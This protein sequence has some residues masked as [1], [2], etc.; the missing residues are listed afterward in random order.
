MEA[1]I[2]KFAGKIIAGL[3]LAANSI[4][5]RLMAGSGMA[6]A[7]F[8]YAYPQIKAVL[9][10]KF[11]ALPPQAVELLTYCAFDTFITVVIS[12]LVARAMTSL[13]LVSL[14]A[15]QDQLNGA[16]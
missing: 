15:L 3:K 7:A 6:F 9:E 13:S 14:T 5:G 2:V 11:L 16:S 4:F 10:S 1:I 12:A 8:Q